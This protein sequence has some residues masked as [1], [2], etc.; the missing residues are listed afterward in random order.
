MTIILLKA[1]IKKKDSH[2][3][4]WTQILW[5]IKKMYSMWPIILTLMLTSIKLNI[6]NRNYQ[7][8]M[9]SNHWVSIGLYFKDLIKTCLG[10]P[11]LFIIAIIIQNSKDRISNCCKYLKKSKQWDPQINKYKYLLSKSMKTPMHFKGPNLL[12]KILNFYKYRFFH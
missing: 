7:N 11:R 5:L 4:Q 3:K 2:N 9:R 10:H 12:G 6:K 1:K 8:S